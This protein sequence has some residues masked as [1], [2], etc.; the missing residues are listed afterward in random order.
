MPRLAVASRLAMRQARRDWRMA[1]LLLII[2]GA[3]LAIST[4]YI[5]VSQ[6]NDLSVRQRIDR[7]LGG[8]DA[9]IT[10]ARSPARAMTVEEW[11]GLEQLR[12]SLP[13]ATA[14]ALVEMESNASVRGRA[15]GLKL[16]LLD[17]RSPLTGPLYLP[18]AGQ[19]PT[20]PGQVALSKGAASRLGLGL[21]SRLDVTGFGEE[22]QVVQLLADPVDTGALFLIMPLTD[23][24]LQQA[25]SSAA[26][27]SL[28]VTYLVRAGREQLEAS[29]LPYLD[30]Q[31][32]LD[33][34]Q[35][36]PSFRTEVIA[37][38][39]AV[40]S[41]V[42]G[43]G[44][45]TISRRQRRTAGLLD[46]A[47]ADRL[48]RLATLLL[49]SLALAVVASVLGTAI[50]AGLAL[51]ILPALAARAAQVWAAPQIPWLPTM[52]LSGASLAIS[53]AV[54]TGVAL[55]TTRY[56]ARQVVGA[57]D[58]ALL[59]PRERS[60][61]LMLAV[62]VAGG[63]AV[64][65]GFFGRSAPAVIVGSVAAASGLGLVLIGSASRLH[66]HYPAGPVWLRM[67]G[68][69]ARRFPSLTRALTLGVSSVGTLASLA[70][71]LLSS[72][73]LST[74]YL[75]ALP[76]GT[77]EFVSSQQLTPAVMGR[78][79]ARLG[80]SRSIAYREAWRSSDGFKSYLQ[81]RNPLYACV[82]EAVGDRSDSVQACSRGTG[83]LIYSPLVAFVDER[84]LA[85]LLGDSWS[86]Q[87]QAGF[88]QG[89]A[90]ARYPQLIDA[91]G[92]IYLESG[93]AVGQT[94][95]GSATW[96]PESTSDRFALRGLLA[97]AAE[98]VERAP[99]VLLPLSRVGSDNLITGTVWHTLFIGSP[100]TPDQEDQARGL[101]VETAFDGQLLVERG[102]PHRAL[103][104]AVTR[105]SA[106]VL[107]TTTGLLTVV[108]VALSAL[109]VR[110]ESAVLSALGADRR[111][112]RLVSA[113][114][115]SVPVASALI[116]ALLVGAVGAR[117][118]VAIE[119][120][121][122][123]SAAGVY[124]APTVLGIVIVAFVAGWFTAP[125]NPGAVR[126]FE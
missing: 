43:A 4:C 92:N 41:V 110:R 33:R 84:D 57:R 64:V 124:L 97:P 35:A 108:F 68:R 82:Q 15:V 34:A 83:F 81:V 69:N 98:Q 42:T 90:I 13:G 63:L 50:G 45:L 10:L 31:G 55:S 53:C 121:T 65:V 8:A 100:P 60:L 28:A 6:N 52:L 1:G 106:L 51:A 102:D 12:R 58:S 77:S 126:A 80:A 44:F 56:G 49:F 104:A 16:V 36:E 115:A 37:G 67:A 78:A 112:R 19:I 107:G 96:N 120:G 25:S 70:G 73:S 114:Q 89:A 94:G 111:L 46:L 109:Q 88:Q 66:D 54:A 9:R 116:I 86:P 11:T 47:G 71:F 40:T 72:L 48:T 123:S 95:G 5:V 85:A 74:G 39:L 32:I 87:L 2:L 62:T 21:G 101:L 18:I 122:W 30:K 22:L 117:A 61:P 29:G 125:A 27:G 7:A 99:A 38:G 17:A 79:A 24:T 103:A 91:N 20:A 26:T 118:G 76:S 93:A 75:P 3:V 59:R 23:A 14:T 105:A 119:N 113:T